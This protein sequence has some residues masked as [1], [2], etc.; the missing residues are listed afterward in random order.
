MTGASPAGPDSTKEHPM[1]STESKITKYSGLAAKHTIAAMDTRAT[2]DQAQQST[3]N[4][5]A[6]ERQLERLRTGHIE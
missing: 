5:R 6:A 2:E 3:N 4:A 1:S